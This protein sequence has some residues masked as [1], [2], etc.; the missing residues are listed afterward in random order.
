MSSES[1]TGSVV[2]VTILFQLGS[3]ELSRMKENLTGSSRVVFA[4]ELLDFLLC[5]LMV[6]IRQNDHVLLVVFVRFS[7]GMNDQRSSKSILVMNSSVRM[8]PIV[9]ILAY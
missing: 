2:I 1:G 5:S 4:H 7:R 9:D 3:F 6:P 8:P